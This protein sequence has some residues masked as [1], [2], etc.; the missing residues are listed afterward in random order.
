MV[1]HKILEI[2]EILVCDANE[3]ITETAKLKY[4][5]NLLKRTTNMKKML[6]K[7]RNEMKR[8]NQDIEKL[9]NYKIVNGNN[10]QGHQNKVDYNDEYS[11]L[12]NE[13]CKLNR[14]DD[15]RSIITYDDLDYEYYTLN[16]E[17][18]CSFKQTGINKTIKSPRIQA[19]SNNLN[20]F[21]IENKFIN[22]TACELESNLVKDNSKLTTRMH[23]I[24]SKRRTIQDCKIIELVCAEN[25]AKNNVT[26]Y[27]RSTTRKILENTVKS[28][29]FIEVKQ[30]VKEM[31]GTLK[32]LSSSANTHSS[33]ISGLTLT[34]KEMCRI[35]NSINQKQNDNETICCNLNDSFTTQIR[36]L[37]SQVE[38]I[39]E[40]IGYIQRRME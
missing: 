8:N 3:L 17:N 11:N 23:E 7:I 22:D 26:N 36:A 38:K 5:E 15:H 13:L 10:S 21:E 14:R 40:I 2:N 31:S 32:L 4:I 30:S 25:N 39:V 19:N 27:A 20:L 24:K 12:S 18:L 16:E 1:A 35:C 28:S 29:E 6:L 9:R 33:A 37:N 34:I